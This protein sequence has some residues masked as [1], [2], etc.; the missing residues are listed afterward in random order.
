MSRLPPSEVLRNAGTI[1]GSP[2][3]ICWVIQA[4]TVMPHPSL[5]SLALFWLKGSHCKKQALL[6]LPV[7]KSQAVLVP[8]SS[9]SESH[10]TS[11]QSTQRLHL[12][13][14]GLCIRQHCGVCRPLRRT[15]GTLAQCTGQEV[16]GAALKE[17]CFPR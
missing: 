3:S 12:T 14:E 13:A 4:G 6:H 16:P 8:L 11:S 15:S 1:L 10:L 2:P 5:A 17:S 7:G 9:Y